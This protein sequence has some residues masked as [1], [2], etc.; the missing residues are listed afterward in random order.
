VKHDKPFVTKASLWVENSIQRA[1]TG[2]VKLVNDYVQD[3]WADNADALKE[4]TN[5]SWFQHEGLRE[6][7]VGEVELLKTLFKWLGFSSGNRE[8]GIPSDKLKLSKNISQI[9]TTG[10]VSELK[11]A[12]KGCMDNGNGIK[13]L[14]GVQD[15]DGKLYQTVYTHFPMTP[16]L[17]NYDKLSEAVSGEYNQFKADYQGSFELQLYKVKPGVTADAPKAAAVNNL[18]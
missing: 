17:K 2:K 4:N 9:I 14:L 3:T 18:F 5:M 6:A 7:Y 1:K 8:K 16:S 11:N 13:Y 10:D 15:K 12:I